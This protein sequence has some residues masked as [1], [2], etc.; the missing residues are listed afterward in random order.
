MPDAK[1]FR[2]RLFSNA[3]KSLCHWRDARPQ[4]LLQT[5]YLLQQL[6]ALPGPERRLL[7]AVLIHKHRARLSPRVIPA[8]R[9]SLH[10]FF[11]T[12]ALVATTESGSS[13]VLNIDTP[14]D[15]LG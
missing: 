5:K 15:R 13:C 12:K 10:C 1:A 8:P 11:V 9:S 6:R 4:T 3:F 14:H 2:L 7:E